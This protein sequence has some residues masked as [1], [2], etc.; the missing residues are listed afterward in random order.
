ML[1]CLGAIIES[2]ILR[3]QLTDDALVVTIHRGRRRY[4]MKEIARTAAR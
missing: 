2:L 4:P 1:V 3:I